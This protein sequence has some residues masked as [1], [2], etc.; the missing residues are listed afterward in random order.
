MPRFFESSNWKRANDVEKF[1]MRGRANKMFVSGG[2]LRYTR[3][4]ADESQHNVPGCP[5]RHGRHE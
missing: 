2:R 5:V 1:S 3:G 4:A